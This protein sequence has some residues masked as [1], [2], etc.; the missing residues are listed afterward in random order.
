M[1]A[2]QLSPGSAPAFVENHPQPHLQPGWA[3]AKVTLAGICRTDLEL[4]QGYMDFKGVPGHEFVGVV[5]SC[6]DEVWVGKRVV[7]EINAACGTCEWCEA[8]LGRHCPQRQVLGI[9]GLD[10]CMA[11][12][13]TL[14]LANLHSVPESLTDEQAVFAEPLSAAY[15]ILDQVEFSGFERCL[16]LG[17]GKLGILCAWVLAT[18]T[19]DVTLLG[20]HA[21]KLEKAAQ[22]GI[23]TSLADDFDGEQADIVVDATGS[24][25][26]LNQAMQHCR[27]RGTLVLKSTVASQGEVNLAPIVIDELNVV[28]SRCG[29]FEHGLA[30]LVTE[31]FPV[32]SLISDRFALDQGAEAF[33]RAAEKGVL[34]VLLQP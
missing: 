33:T 23:K 16:V 29:L 32:E 27:P 20:R 8:D 26:G 6:E 1:K 11:A 3:L 10:G 24:G 4:A 13:C 2:I 28:G 18:V 22:R 14:P 12:Y 30:G 7:G 31:G 19:P 25:A 34:K 5:E 17:D 21:T 9:L 15:E